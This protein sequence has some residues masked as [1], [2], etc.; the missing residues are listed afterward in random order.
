MGRPDSECEMC[1][2][3]CGCLCVIFFCVLKDFFLCLRAVVSSG[4]LES[5]RAV[6][7]FMCVQLSGW[8]C[9][10]SSPSPSSLP[11]SD[12]FRFVSVHISTR[13]L[14]LL[15][16]KWGRATLSGL[17]YVYAALPPP[18]LLSTL[19]C[20]ASAVCLAIMAAYSHRQALVLHFTWPASLAAISSF[21]ASTSLLLFLLL[22]FPATQLLLCRLEHAHSKVFA[23]IRALQLHTWALLSLF[24]VHAFQRL[25]Q[26]SSNNFCG[27]CTRAWRNLSRRSHNSRRYCAD[28]PSEVLVA[29]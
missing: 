23:R 17:N 28:C 2:C 9:R 5:C 27:Q 1:V 18:L 3:V 6:G 11:C 12:R 8:S 4:E 25:S 21:T 24:F 19:C 14:Q 15:P 20:W 16:G 26:T 22:F 7:Y 13:L 29:F 10:L